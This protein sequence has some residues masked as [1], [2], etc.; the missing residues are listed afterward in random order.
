MKIDTEKWV[1]PII[2]AEKLNVSLQVV[3]N[4]ITRGKVKVLH[5]PEW[6]IIRLVDAT[7]TPKQKQ[8]YR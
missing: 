6:R 2:L 3:N 7:F 8:P 5:V 1:P 4:W